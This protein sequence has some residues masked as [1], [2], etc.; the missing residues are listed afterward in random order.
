MSS[1][2]L[3][4]DDAHAHMHAHQF[5]DA[6]QQKEAVVLGMWA[7]LATEVLF[8]GALFTT[9]VVF[10]FS[11]PKM[12]FAASHE[13]DWKLGC[14]NTFIL[15]LS[16]FTM[17][18]A[19]NAAQRGLKARINVCLA[20]TFLLAGGFLVV[21]TIEYKAKYDHGLIP[22]PHFQIPDKMAKEIGLGD[23]PA[24]VEALLAPGM[25]NPVAGAEHAAAPHG[26][27]PAGHA[28]PAA[29][30]AGGEHHEAIYSSESYDKFRHPL[31]PKFSDDAR[32]AQLFF[33]LYFA[34]TGLHA[35]HVIIG[36]FAIAFLMV[37]TQRNWF[38]E[39]YNSPVEMT[40]LYWHFVDIVWV[41]LFPLLYL[42]DIPK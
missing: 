18:L 3:H 21:K 29:E 20:A 32:K 39:H 12:W 10:R 26:A 38:N 7:F 13:L 23:D 14:L 8:F 11:Y 35:F 27:E 19:V 25:Q 31:T 15:L 17:A 6:E 16:S 34:M 24:A 28:A 5:E 1:T 33:A 4:A 40:G 30:H 41:F 9:Y 36:M 42:M 22:G 2:T 37:L